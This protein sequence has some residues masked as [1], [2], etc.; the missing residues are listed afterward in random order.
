MELAF[1]HVLDKTVYL[2]NPIPEG[3]G[4]TDEIA[5]MQP[6]I[7]NGDLTKIR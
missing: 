7:L 2:M 5:A 4:Y 3:L 6:T 1:G